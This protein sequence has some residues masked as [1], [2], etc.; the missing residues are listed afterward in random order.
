MRN[1][2]KVG[3][4]GEHVKPAPGL[5]A[6]NLLLQGGEPVGEGDEVREEYDLKR[7]VNLKADAILKAA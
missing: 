2:G 5:H 7:Q 3:E 4:G 1:N 6:P